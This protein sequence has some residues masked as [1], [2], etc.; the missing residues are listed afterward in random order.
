MAFVGM[1][2]CDSR[3]LWI[4]TAVPPWGG[5]FCMFCILLCA[6][7]CFVSL[8]SVINGMCS[9]LPCSTVVSSSVCMFVSIAEVQKGERER[10]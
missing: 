4:K 7:F 10:I 2:W 3:V 9:F 5:E 8:V 1:T 6:G